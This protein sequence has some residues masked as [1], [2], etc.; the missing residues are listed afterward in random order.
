[1][2]G[3]APH[4]DNG[5]N[6]TIQGEAADSSTPKR[7]RRHTR[8]NDFWKL[9]HGEKVP[10]PL[11]EFGAPVRDLSG[12]YCNFLGTIARHSTYCPLSYEQWPDVPIHMK[13]K[14]WD[15]EVLSRCEFI[16][17]PD[18]YSPIK[19][20]TISNIGQKWRNWKYYIKSTH[21]DF[22]KE[23]DENVGDA[24][25]WLKER[26]VC[27][28]QYR[29]LKVSKRGKTNKS[30]GKVPHAAGS[31]AFR[32][33]VHDMDSLHNVI[34]E[35]EEKLAQDDQHGDEKSNTQAGIDP[36]RPWINDGYSKV[37]GADKGSIVSLM[38]HLTLG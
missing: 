17:A 8:M 34:R 36:S 25:L 32:R 13:N 24:K 5:T 9:K 37:M 4:G 2:N 11:N 10:I 29:S 28:D 1:M 33:I 20:W 12:S 14:I 35:E 38:G 6:R 23:E 18:D 7:A 15:D 30:N 16:P 22:T 31:K 19:I 21:F 27:L 26:G 3:D